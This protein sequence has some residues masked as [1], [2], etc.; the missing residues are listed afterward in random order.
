MLEAVDRQ[1]SYVA[2]VQL[3]AVDDRVGRL[4]ASIAG[5]ASNSGTYRAFYEMQSMLDGRDPDFLKTFR[6]PDLN[7]E[8]RAALMGDARNSVYE[9]KHSEQ[10]GALAGIRQ[11]MGLTDL[12][13][14]NPDGR[15]M[16]SVT[17]SDDF[18][19]TMNDPESAS[20]K[21]LFDAVMGSTERRVHSTPFETYAFTGESSAI[22][23]YPIFRAGAAAEAKPDAVLVFRLSTNSISQ[24]FLN[25]GVN[26]N[27]L[28]LH[29]TTASGEIIASNR[30][31]LIGNTINL[32]GLA[33]DAVEQQQI[34]TASLNNVPGF[35]QALTSV[36]SV[37]LNNDVFYLVAAYDMD[38]ALSGIVTM[39]NL[40]VFAALIAVAIFCV[41]GIFFGRAVS[42]PI[43]VITRDMERLAKGDT[44][45]KE[46]DAEF[47]NEIGN[48]A[49]A[50]EV[51]RQNAIENRRLSEESRHGHE[52]QIKRQKE[53]DALICQF[54]EQALHML[55]SVTNKSQEMQKAAEALSMIAS[56][57][58]NQAAEA[59]ATIVKSDSSLQVVAG[60]AEEL[61]TS[62]QEISRQ[63]QMTATVV[64]EATEHTRTT[65]ERISGLA[66][67][68]N[69]IGEVVSLI[70]EIAEQTNLLALNA[71][72][73]AAR[74]GEAGKG[75][76][77]VASEV[78]SLATQTAKATETISKQIS[79]IQKST[80]EAVEATG[81]IAKT[82]DTVNDY[83][84]SIAAAVEEQGAATRE[85]HHNV[86]SVAQGSGNVTNVM[87][88]LT[89][90][91]S[92][93]NDS[94]EAVNG[95]AQ[96]V[97]DNANALRETVET[98]LKKVSD[99]QQAA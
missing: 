3:D 31:D 18:Y 6:R 89:E 80:G 37:T 66:K 51:F 57:A 62:V 87:N 12:L 28:A 53:I 98:F 16:Y 11:D 10:H 17:K 60:A 61:A 81:T 79:D 65:N 77:V 55:T 82:M 4:S 96:S 68:A 46:F 36:A 58:S 44:E 83:T 25:A 76:A 50:V 48:M 56:Q 84:N 29:F 22:A 47:R 94:A 39:R 7:V 35:G 49:S 33:S 73:E 19:A 20:L 91:V 1:L 24:V 41:A 54:R 26:E 27:E 30:E 21:A 34:V 42:A 8:E 86:A 99:A 43:E 14:I 38:A 59:T 74:A 92:S 2:Q 95:A 63:V 72:I 15:V 93:T 9:W 23:A 71:T 75:F 88:Q 64:S 40:M 45:N 70:S 78:K 90:G 67:A 32:G 5:V 85:I 97:D 13:I 69:E 52:V